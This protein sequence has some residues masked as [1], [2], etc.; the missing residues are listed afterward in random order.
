[1]V[2]WLAIALNISVSFGGGVFIRI[3]HLELLQMS[4]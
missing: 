2:F 4:R 3:N 1:M